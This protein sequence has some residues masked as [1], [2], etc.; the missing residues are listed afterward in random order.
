MADRFSVV[1]GRGKRRG[2][3]ENLEKISFRKRQKS[4]EIW[5]I[6]RLKGKYQTLRALFRKKNRLR[7]QAIHRRMQNLNYVNKLFF[8]KTNT[9][10]FSKIFQVKY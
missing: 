7:R 1:S 5:Y 6:K 2:K 8:A 10:N 9:K 4:Y 3:C